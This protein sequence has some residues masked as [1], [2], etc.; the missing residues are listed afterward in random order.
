MHILEK[1]AVAANCA[2]HAKVQEQYWQKLRAIVSPLCFNF[3]LKNQADL[4]FRLACEQGDRAL[5]RHLA[6]I[7]AKGR[8]KRVR[9]NGKRPRSG[10]QLARPRTIARAAIRSR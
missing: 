8:T 4:I 6:R 9:R 1:A 3:L 2:H 7:S 5:L 10:V